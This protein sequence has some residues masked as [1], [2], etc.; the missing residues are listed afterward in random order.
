MGRRR[1]PG[2]WW[3]FHWEGDKIA[4]IWVQSDADYLPNPIQS[5]PVVGTGPCDRLLEDTVVPFIKGLEQGRID[6]R[7]PE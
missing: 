7:R 6:P 5:F 3:D 1:V 4:S 2:Y